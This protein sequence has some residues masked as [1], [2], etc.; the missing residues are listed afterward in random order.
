MFNWLFGKYCIRNWRYKLDVGKGLPKFTNQLAKHLHRY[1]LLSRTNS[2]VMNSKN[3][4]NNPKGTDKV[5][6][7]AT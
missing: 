4:Q 1:M 5:I 3:L 7:A 6:R 2:T